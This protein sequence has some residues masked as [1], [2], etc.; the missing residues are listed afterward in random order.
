MG[1]QSVLRLGNLSWDSW[2]KRGLFFNIKIFQNRDFSGTSV[3]YGA[4]IHPEID[5]GPRGGL[6]CASGWGSYRC[7]CAQPDLM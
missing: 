1:V 4:G 7:D 3:I 5:P 2:A 6:V